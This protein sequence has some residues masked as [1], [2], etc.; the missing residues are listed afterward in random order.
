MIELIKEGRVIKCIENS[1]ELKR[2]QDEGFKIKEEIKEEQ[3]TK[4]PVRKKR[5]TKKVED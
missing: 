3:E 4:K 2:L 1:I 5:T